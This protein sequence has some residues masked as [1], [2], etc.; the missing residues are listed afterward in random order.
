MSAITRQPMDQSTRQAVIN[1]H[2]WRCHLC[3]HAINPMTLAGPR[4][5]H[6]DHVLPVSRGGCNHL[7]NLRPSH[8]RCNLAKGN[9]ASRRVCPK[10]ATPAVVR[11]VAFCSLY[12]IVWAALTVVGLVNTDATYRSQWIGAAA[13]WSG[14]V[15]VLVI[16]AVCHLVRQASARHADKQVAS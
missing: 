3:A 1:R 6:I 11:T 9:Q 15:L 5:L 4:S 13:F 2:G 14:P 7:G 10:C 16:I 12:T 8:A